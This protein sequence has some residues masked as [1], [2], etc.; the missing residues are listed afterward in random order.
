MSETWIE[1]LRRIDRRGNGETV[2]LSSATRP[3]LPAMPILGRA[4][5]ALGKTGNSL[6]LVMT[7]VVEALSA[8]RV[9]PHTI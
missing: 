1:K 4:G 3:E 9:G 7:D 6:G 5:P 2:K 8:P